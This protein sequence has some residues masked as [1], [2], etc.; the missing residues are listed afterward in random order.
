MTGLRVTKVGEHR[1]S[2]LGLNIRHEPTQ[3]V[4][5]ALPWAGLLFKRRNLGLRHAAV[6]EQFRASDEGRIR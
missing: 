3:G 6:H 1:T 5:L 4:A 2:L